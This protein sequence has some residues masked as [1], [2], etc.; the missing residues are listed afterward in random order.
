M[1]LI[2]GE[3]AG[4]HERYML[5]VPIYRRRD[6]TLLAA[7][8]I[9]IQI[10]IVEAAAAARLEVD[11]QHVVVRPRHL[12]QLHLRHVAHAEAQGAVVHLQP[13]FYRTESMLVNTHKEVVRR[14]PCLACQA[15]HRL[16][17]S[18]SHPRRQLHLLLEQLTVL[19]LR[20]RARVAHH[21]VVRPQAPLPVPHIP[22]RGPQLPAE[23]AQITT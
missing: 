14:H 1:C 13:P 3:I 10:D 16:D 22:H 19:H 11:R 6:D 9:Y 5:M 7:R 12:L 21:R 15:G 20:L 2:S 18:R 23:P 8:H 17:N 4:H